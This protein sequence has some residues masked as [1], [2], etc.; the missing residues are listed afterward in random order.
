VSDL[1]HDQLVA[2]VDRESARLRAAL[3]RTSTRAVVPSTPEW[4]AADL[5]WHVGEVQC[6]WAAVV[7]DLVEDVDDLAGPERPADEDLPAFLAR[8]SQDLVAALQRRSPQDACWSWHEDGGQVGWVAR[9]QAHEALIHRV[10][11]ELAAGGPVG[12]ADADL[13]A[14]GIDELLVGLLAPPSWASFTPDGADVAVVTTD[15]GHAWHV[16]LGRVTGT[17]PRTGTTFEEEAA[18]R[19]RAGEGGTVG[20]TLAGRAWD[21]DRWLW[22]RGPADPL[23]MAGEHGLLHHLR[24]IAE[25]E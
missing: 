10:D 25:V 5:A 24:A 11:A 8:S 15:T 2:V 14:D 4:S 16:E 20:A 1:D 19:T 9:R 22:G 17:S 18:V 6:F 12:D 13:A 23:R 7:A 21:V 3:R